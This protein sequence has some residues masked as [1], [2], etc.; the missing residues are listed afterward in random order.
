M[1]IIIST[2]VTIITIMVMTI[3]MIDYDNPSSI[4]K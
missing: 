2:I 4:I 1:T 3:Y